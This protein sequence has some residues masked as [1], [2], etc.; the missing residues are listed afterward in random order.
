MNISNIMSNTVDLVNSKLNATETMKH[1]G[2]NKLTKCTKVAVFVAS[3]LAVNA[4]ALVA[5]GLAVVVLAPAIIST[6][7]VMAL[8]SAS[9][10]LGA[11]FIA[12]LQNPKYFDKLLKTVDNDIRNFL[13]NVS[14]EEMKNLGKTLKED[15]MALLSHNTSTV[16]KPISEPT[17][18]GGKSTDYGDS[19][20]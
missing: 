3:A 14:L 7:G 19:Q 9:A 15:I 1:V 12:Y 6:L 8:I 20:S 18:P 17:N 13:R 2:D 11:S 5:L 10:A 4:V 16:Q